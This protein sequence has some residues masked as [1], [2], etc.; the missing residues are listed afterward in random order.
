MDLLSI[1]FKGNFTKLDTIR[2]S[3]LSLDNTEINLIGANCRLT[4]V[5]KEN[6]IL[7]IVNHLFNESSNTNVREIL[8]DYFHEIIQKEISITKNGH[9]SINWF[10]DAFDCKLTNH[11]MEKQINIKNRVN[12]YKSFEMINWRSNL[13]IWCGF[14]INIIIFIVYKISSKVYMIYTSFS[15]D[16]HPFYYYISI[17]MMLHEILGLFLFIISSGQALY[18]F[19]IVDNM[20][21]PFNLVF[22]IF[23]LNET[24]N[25][26]LILCSIMSLLTLMK[27][28]KFYLIAILELLLL[29]SFI[30]IN[31]IEVVSFSTFDFY[32]LK[33]ISDEFNLMLYFPML[34]INSGEQTFKII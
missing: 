27:M 29:V 4:I 1:S 5:T 14:K 33:I 13:V 8:V 10:D 11:I 17:I 28:I 19:W 3:I 15:Y 34:M 21:V 2:K 12:L 16:I 31:V 6:P 18:R 9:Y 23:M 26:L 22:L 32:L 30:M 20:L 7:I 25:Y 24:D